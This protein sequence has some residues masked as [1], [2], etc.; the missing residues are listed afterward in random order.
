MIIIDRT[1]ELN[2]KHNFEIS[3]FRM[4]SLSILIANINYNIDHFEMFSDNPPGGPSIEDLNPCAEGQTEIQTEGNYSQDQFDLDLQEWQNTKVERLSARCEALRKAQKQK[5]MARQ[6][7][8]VAT[9][10]RE[11]L[12]LKT[13]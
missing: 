13:Y 3:K 11:L 12:K 1:G 6:T 7:R 8:R 10:Q 9:K 5:Q 2:S 4:T